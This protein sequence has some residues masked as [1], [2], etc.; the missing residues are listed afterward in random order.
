MPDGPIVAG[1][2]PEDVTLAEPG[3][4]GSL[5]ARVTLVEH[6]GLTTLIHTE[7]DGERVIVLTLD[8]PAIAEG[9]TVG[10]TLDLGKLH[11][12]DRDTTLRIAA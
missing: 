1:I 10:L 3:A 9:E 7:T 2:R 4:P 5:P 12:F 6:S 8:R 11:L